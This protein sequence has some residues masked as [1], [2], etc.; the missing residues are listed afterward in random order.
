MNDKAKSAAGDPVATLSAELEGCRRATN[1]CIAIALGRGVVPG[2]EALF[3]G[4]PVNDFETCFRFMELALKLMNTSSQLGEAIA[5]LKGELRQSITVDKYNHGPA[6]ARAPQTL[7][8]QKLRERRENARAI[9]HEG[10]GGEPEAEKR[11]G[12]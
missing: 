6:G 5:R 4:E 11:M 1:Y 3:A 8:T 9:Q 10:E 2:E 7:S 12:G